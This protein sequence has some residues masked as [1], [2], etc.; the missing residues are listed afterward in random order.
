MSRTVKEEEI[1]CID[2]GG[3]HQQVHQSK[4]NRDREAYDRD[5]SLKI[6]RKIWLTST[7]RRIS[8]CARVCIQLGQ[9][10]PAIPDGDQVI[11]ELVCLGQMRDE[12]LQIFRA[13]SRTEGS[14]THEERRRQ[15]VSIHE[16]KLHCAIRIPEHTQ[17]HHRYESPKIYQPLGL[18]TGNSGVP[19]RGA[20]A[21]KKY[22][23]RTDSPRAV[24]GDCHSI[25]QVTFREQDLGVITRR[26]GCILSEGTKNSK[27][28]R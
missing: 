12:L 25:G 20:R 16:P 9:D 14:D 13:E 18:E 26:D 24:S 8:R 5:L 23:G 15:E 4:I 17:D 3:S 28:G 6:I 11:F 21:R 10:S 1:Y 22:G 19:R 27:P 7:H 2:G